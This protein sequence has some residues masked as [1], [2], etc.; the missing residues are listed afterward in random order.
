MGLEVVLYT[1]DYSEVSRAVVGGECK[2]Y[3]HDGRLICSTGAH[4]HE[5]SNCTLLSLRPCPESSLLDGW[6]VSL[7]LSPFFLLKIGVST[8]GPT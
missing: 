6:M 7:H 4:G 1:G 8:T 3:N 2:L 5:P